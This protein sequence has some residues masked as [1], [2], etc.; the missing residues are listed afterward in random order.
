MPV[1]AFITSTC[2]PGMTPELVSVTRPVIWAVWA[3]I[4]WQPARRAMVPNRGRIVFSYSLLLITPCGGASRNSD[5]RH[6]GLLQTADHSAQPRQFSGK[7][8][9]SR[10][11]RRLGR[12]GSCKQEP[13]ERSSRLADSSKSVPKEPPGSPAPGFPSRTAQAEPPA[14]AR[15]AN[16][17]SSPAASP[18]DPAACPRDPIGWRRAGR[19]SSP[20]EIPSPA[21]R[22][23]MLAPRRKKKAKLHRSPKLRA[24][25]AACAAGKRL[26]II[27]RHHLVEFGIASGPG[28]GVDGCAPAGALAVSPV[29]ILPG[30]ESENRR[31]PGRGAPPNFVAPASDS[32]PVLLITTRPEGSVFTSMGSPR[33]TPRRCSA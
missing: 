4:A 17:G 25:T 16:S 11:T 33:Q 10:Q 20:P 24:A 13:D 6:T 5:S 3:K 27:L 26:P 2:T 30:S 21:S 19:V 9:S 1:F 29:Q 7:V 22:S 23:P 28:R 15:A 18:D 31:T 8:V 32:R 12:C 14:P